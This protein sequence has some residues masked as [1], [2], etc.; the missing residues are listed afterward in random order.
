ML[1][2]NR[3][4]S[5]NVLDAEDCGVFKRRN[6][7]AVMETCAPKH[8]PIRIAKLVEWYERQD[9]SEDNIVKIA[10]EFKYRFLLI[11]PFSDGNVRMSRI[12][13]NNMISS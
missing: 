5:S 2:L 9:K 10:T 12:L 6:T 4:I 11:H 1:L 3:V 8:V 13:F 7:I